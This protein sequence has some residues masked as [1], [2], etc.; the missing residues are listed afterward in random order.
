[1]RFAVLTESP[2]NMGSAGERTTGVDG[3]DEH[4]GSMPEECG[5]PRGVGLAFV[6][7]RLRL[8]QRLREL[9]E[10]HEQGLALDMAMA[11]EELEAGAVALAANVRDLLACR[12][13]L[14]TWARAALYECRAL[15]DAISDLFAACLRPLPPG[16]AS[17]EPQD[18]S[19][20]I[21]YP[22][23]RE[24]LAHHAA[25]IEFVLSRYDE[26]LDSPGAHDER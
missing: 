17:C 9:K 24:S 10:A 2:R 21:S 3:V 14:V 8:Q 23:L 15:H 1:M 11:A 22:W 25:Q 13:N 7:A 20:A 12:A 16:V 6:Q 5:D 4:E 26:W 18:A 19:P